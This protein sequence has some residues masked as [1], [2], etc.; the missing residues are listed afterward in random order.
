[1]PHQEVDAEG[2]PQEQRCHAPLG[3]AQR[4]PQPLDEQGHGEGQGD[5]PCHPAADESCGTHR[6]FLHM[7]GTELG[8]TWASGDTSYTPEAKRARSDGRFWVDLARHSQYW[9]DVSAR[10]EVPRRGRPK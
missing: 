9:G 7:D 1:G 3:G 6:G 2:H 8:G 4:E 10:L 5:E